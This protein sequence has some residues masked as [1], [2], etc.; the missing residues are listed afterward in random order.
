MVLVLNWW[1]KENL[2]FIFTVYIILKYTCVVSLR[3]KVLCALKA[4]ERKTCTVVC[5]V[6][7]VWFSHCNSTS[8]T[9]FNYESLLNVLLSLILLD[10][11]STEQ[12]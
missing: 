11:C 9:L 8:Q 10:E 12:K 4:G 3:K 2:K 6:S 7:G 1:F 5:C